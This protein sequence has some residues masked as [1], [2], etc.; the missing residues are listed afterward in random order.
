MVRHKTLAGNALATGR[1][2]LL[3]TRWF[4]PS[5]MTSTQHCQL[6]LQTSVVRLSHVL[7]TVNALQDINMAART[8]PVSEYRRA[9]WQSR[10]A[11]ASAGGV[12]TC[13]LCVDVVAWEGGVSCAA[14]LL[15]YIS[16]QR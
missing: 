2:L 1:S 16:E 10:A 12:P 5:R 4:I 11:I 9:Y 15:V 3:A 13:F 8:W 6:T 14:W 7:M